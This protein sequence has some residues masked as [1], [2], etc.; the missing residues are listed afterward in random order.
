MQYTSLT[1]DKKTN[2]LI[3]RTLFYVNV[4]GR[5]RLLKQSGFLPTLYRLNRLREFHQ[6]DNLG[7]V[8]DKVEL[9]SF[10][11]EK[12][13]CKGHDR[14]KYCQNV[15]VYASSLFLQV[16]V[17]ILSRAFLTGSDRQYDSRSPG[18]GTV[19]L[20]Q[21][22]DGSQSTDAT[23]GESLANQRDWSVL[24]TVLDRVCFTLSITAVV[25][26]LLIFFPRWLRCCLT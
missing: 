20:K 13:K 21:S 5:Y 23:P 22:P 4:Y 24:L 19:G 15:E 10:W 16:F 12:V 6:I 17:G 11:G 9:F 1:P 25:A 26:A 7:A 3:Y 8:G 14:T 2:S 18:G